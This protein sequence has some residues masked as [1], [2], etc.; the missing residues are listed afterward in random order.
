MYM[1]SIF[2]Y[3]SFVCTVFVRIHLDL[4]LYYKKRTQREAVDLVRVRVS[5]QTQ[6]ITKLDE[7][8]KTWK[9]LSVY[10]SSLLFI[11]KKTEKLFR[12]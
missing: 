8:L 10:V 2:V 12:T 7:I 4:Q 3:C 1:C 6:K 11:Y 9:L 5:R